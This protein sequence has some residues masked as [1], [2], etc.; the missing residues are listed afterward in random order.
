[1]IKRI[2][3]IYAPV[4]PGARKAELLALLGPYLDGL[5]D[6]LFHVYGEQ[7][8]AVEVLERVLRLAH[9]RFR[10]ERFE[11]YLRPWIFRITLET[12]MGHYPGYLEEHE[13]REAVPLW[14]LPPEEKMAVMLRDRGGFT[15]DEIA[16]VLHVTEGRLGR[17]LAYGRE[18]I[19]QRLGA[20]S[21]RE[22]L[23]KNPGCHL[24]SL[25]A[26]AR[27][28]LDASGKCPACRVYAQGIE[29]ARRFVADLPEMKFDS[30]E[31]S[32]RQSR[33]LP[34]LAQPRSLRWGDLRWHTKLVLEG[35][36]LALVGLL[37]VVVAPRLAAKID[38]DALLAGR[39]SSVIR[40]EAEGE[41]ETEISAERLLASA[42]VGAEVPEAAEESENFSDMDFPSGDFYE[43]GAAPVAPSRQNALVYRLIV[44]SSN[45]RE[46]APKVREVF[47][48]RNVKEREK[49]G[50]SLPGGVF[51][52]GVTNV[53]S[54]PQ[55]L[56][57][58]QKLGK[59]KTYSNPDGRR[60]PAERARVIVWIQQI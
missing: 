17:D 6:F 29:A 30:V 11:R 31:A 28:S 38:T 19:A 59:T 34:I 45:P 57:S 42:S 49:S 13:D 53:G 55:I 27:E 43:T 18:A 41:V 21:W 20:G 40:S 32:V 23:K 60:N 46:T 9:R 3:Q 35:A 47:E 1:M 7:A 15:S 4:L 10:R 2:R 37:A 58:I 54:F 5:Y 8:A 56:E 33:I 44:Q 22:E 50:Q 25:Q 39:F 12:V 51:F 52:D 26:R 16:Q 24:V 48:G 36:A 14:Y